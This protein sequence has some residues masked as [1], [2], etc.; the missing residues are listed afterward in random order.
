MVQVFRR[1][2]SICETGRLVFQGLD[3]GKLY[4]VKNVDNPGA[5]DIVKGADLA[6]KGIEIALP[7]RPA[8][9][10]LV[11]RATK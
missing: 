11:Y 3:P 2:R 6:A 5:E 9:A 10:I 4:A 7:A 1:A 8:S